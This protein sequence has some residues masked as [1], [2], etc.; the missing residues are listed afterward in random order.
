MREIFTENRCM[1]KVHYHCLMT[2]I[3]VTELS[4]PGAQHDVVTLVH[5]DEGVVLHHCQ[6]E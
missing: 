6:R 3:V 4:I 1:V 2:Y 5:S